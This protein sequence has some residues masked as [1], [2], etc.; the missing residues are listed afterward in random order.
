LELWH[1][2]DS[3]MT[4]RLMYTSL[5]KIDIIRKKRYNLII[6]TQTPLGLDYSTDML[7]ED[8]IWGAELIHAIV[9]RGRNN[10]VITHIEISE[11][12]SYM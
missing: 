5:Y 3:S 7:K 2:E 10:S 1:T 9:E 4:L 12:I 11:E 8:Y 6:P